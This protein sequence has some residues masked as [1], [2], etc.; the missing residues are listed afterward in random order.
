MR[1]TRRS[2]RC[3][4]RQTT[5]L[6]H[7]RPCAEAPVQVPVPET[8]S[9]ARPV[10]PR[11]KGGWIWAVAGMAA[12]SM[13]CLVALVVTLSLLPFKVRL[14]VGRSRSYA[15]ARQRRL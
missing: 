4:T 1:S 6:A 14:T 7:T 15:A 12:L 10:A 3:C 5:L 9:L 2:R 13:L 8:P 11:K